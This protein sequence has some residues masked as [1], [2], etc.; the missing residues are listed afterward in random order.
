MDKH[1]A[2][3]TAHLG[4]CHCGAL[5]FEVEVDLA[6]GVSR[7]NCTICTKVG[8][9]GAVV[10]PEAFRALSDEA[11]LGQYAF[12]GKTARRYFCR[13]GRGPAARGVD[14]TL[15][16]GDLVRGGSR[17]TRACLHQW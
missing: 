9:S 10:E 14:G 2:N 16:L 5:R 11:E 1:S 12:G 8:S 15:Y 17:Q 7:C 3:A 4:S 6:G 13:P